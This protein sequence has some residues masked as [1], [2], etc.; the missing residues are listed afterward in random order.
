[1]AA[2]ADVGAGSVGTG[3]ITRVGIGGER[4]AAIVCSWVLRVGRS[5]GLQVVAQQRR[6]TGRG[7]Y[8]V[9]VGV[10]GF[11]CG[12]RCGSGVQ[13]GGGGTVHK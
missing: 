3:M 11:G 2:G 4:R 6:V 10:Y 8:R 12:C 13:L 1:M 9:C 5:R 7:V